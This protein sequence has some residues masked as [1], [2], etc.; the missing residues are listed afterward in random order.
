MKARLPSA[1]ARLAS[2]ALMLGVSAGTAH[3]YAVPTHRAVS[4]VALHRTD[5]RVDQY[6]KDELVLPAGIDAPGGTGTLAQRLEQGAQDEDDGTRARN[7]FYNPITNGGLD[8]VFSGAPSLEWAYNDAGNPY[9]WKGARD[10]YYR[11]FTS[12]SPA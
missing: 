4:N 3:A 2:T 8:D 7:H 5:C 11:A 1:V 6:L 10:A 12:A 9:G